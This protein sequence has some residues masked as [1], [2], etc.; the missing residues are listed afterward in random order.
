MKAVAGTKIRWAKTPEGRVLQPHTNGEAKAA[1]TREVSMDGTPKE[2]N[3]K[4]AEDIKKWF[5]T[6]LSGGV[7]GW[8]AP[9]WFGLFL[10]EAE[11]LY[12]KRD[13]QWTSLGI[14]I[15]NGQNETNV[16]PSKKQVHIRLQ[17]TTL[18]E[19]DFTLYNL[20]HETIHVLGPVL[21][22]E[23]NFLEEGVA[24]LF[25]LE[26]KHY[27]DANCCKIM[28]SQLCAD[29]NNY[30]PALEDV[31]SLLRLRR[32]AIFQLRKTEKYLSRITP[33]QIVDAVPACPKELSAR[34]RA[35]FY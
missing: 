31:E 33:S 19:H 17:S 34:L 21:K 24:T 7:F 16:C 25:A 30:R 28:R 2:P 3:D 22:D 8:T 23:V 26:L 35:K 1:Q 12:G 11:E 20:A 9:T 5:T 27:N 10:S 18:N 6:K 4:T 14:E 29:K 13:C 32:D 15:S